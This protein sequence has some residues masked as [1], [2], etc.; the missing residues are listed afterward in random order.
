MNTKM[1][2]KTCWSLAALVGILLGR[3]A[4]ARAQINTESLRTEKVQPGVHGFFE[5]SLLWQRGNTDLLQ[6]GLGARLEYNYK[7][8]NPFLQ[9]TYALGQK[10]NEK[11]LHNGFLHA[12]WPAMWHKR[13][14]SELF[15]QLQFDEFKR[16]NLRTLIGAGVRIA[17]VLHKNITLY[18]GTGYMFEYE[19]LDLEQTD[20]P[21]P[22]P[23][24][25]KSHRW[26]SY[27]SLHF[28]VSTWVDITNI[29]Y[30]QPRFDRMDD[31]R[32]LEDLSLTLTIYKNLKL[33]LSFLLDYDS[34]PP[35]AVEKLDTKLITKLRFEF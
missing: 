13:V 23:A 26:T 34:D 16:L 32:V 9:G 8:H 1:I 5:G 31:I 15:T 2:R 30:A 12:R 20:P 11:F 25:T 3:A 27:L 14:G 6:A 22:H 18:V 21:D 7:I 17:A 19:K 29:T 28:Q 10:F 35:Q 4:P 24:V 33:V